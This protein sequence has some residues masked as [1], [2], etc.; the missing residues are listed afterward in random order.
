MGYMNIDGKNVEICGERNILEVIRK[1]GIDLPTLCYVPEI[2]AYG[3]CRMCVVED[4]R[5]MIV[6]SCTTP[7]A[8]GMVVKTNTP[9]VQRIRRM[10]L[11]LILA[12]HNREC[13]T[14]PK[15]G[16]CRLQDL[17]KRFAIRDIRFPNKYVEKPIDKSSPSIVR[18]ESKCILCS[19]CVRTCNEI[20]D[21]G[22]IGLSRRGANTRVTCAFDVPLAESNCIN[23]G[24]CITA[25]PTGALYTPSQE[26]EVWKAIDDPEKY[27]V[28]S[29]APAVRV[30]IAEEFGYAPGEIGTGRMVAAMRRIGFNEIFDTNFAADLTTLEETAEFLKRYTEKKNLPLFTSCCP[31]WV[32]TA[33]TFYPE[34]LSNVSTCRSPQQ[35]YGSVMV[36]NYTELKGIDRDKLYVVSVMPCTAKKFEANRPEF[37]HD[38]HQDIDAV[39][40][41]TEL[42]EMIKTAGIN[43]DELEDDNFDIPF[44]F[45]TGA[46]TIFG[47]TGG[48]A[49][50]VV[51]QAKF[52]LAGVRDTNE[53]EMTS[54]PDFPGLIT[55][56]IPIP[57][58]AV[59]H[60]AFVSGMS[61]IRNVL[62]AMDEGELNFDIVEVMAC[63]GGCVG[64][65]GQPCPNHTE[66]RVERTVGLHE[67]D[68]MHQLRISEDNVMVKEL[69]RSWLKET[70][71]EEAHE[72][73]HTH[74]AAR[75]SETQRD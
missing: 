47:Y 4:G 68:A 1:S 51:R 7:P 54:H 52:L 18:D 72:W 49:T 74:Y 71:S 19:A 24:Q 12:N 60:L 30:A 37:S 33:E 22:A 36:H 34:K 63:P 35:M 14:C 75:K 55:S 67:D 32:K 6:T 10:M 64:G 66:Q 56:D 28:V 20:Q 45:A 58:D 50:A 26:Q 57:G 53:F 46:G 3:A 27:V 65:G 9:R 2:S 21:I 16:K 15:N 73:L 25:C 44:G 13:T 11:E 59:V 17:C 61:N 31:A 69:Y 43:F 42:A 40:T 70:N 23:C 39:I 48:V 38:G 41:T 5:G 62:K 29:I 8:D